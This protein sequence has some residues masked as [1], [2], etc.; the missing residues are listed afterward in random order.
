MMSAIQESSALNVAKGFSPRSIPPKAGKVVVLSS[1][2]LTDRMFLYTE[3][4]ETLEEFASTKVW[5][6]SANSPYGEALWSG[7]PVRIESF[8]EVRAFREFPHNYLR[9]LN[10]FVWDLRQ[11]PPSRL[12]MMRHVR[13]KHQKLSIRMLKLPAI[14]LSLMRAEEM[15]ETKLERLLLAY[16]RSQSATLR[17]RDDRP[18][19]L[20]TT[21]PFQFE[22]PAIVAAAR[23]LGIKTL[24]LIP[25]WD[26]VSTKNRMVF[27]YDGYMVWSEQGK[28]EL[29]QF[30]P[31]TRKLPVYVI[32]AP[33]FDTFFQPEFTQSRED[34]CASQELNPDLPI[35][36]YAVGSPNFLQEHYGAIQLA[37]KVVKG[38]LG[39]VQMLIRPHPIHDNGEMRRVF[40]RFRPR[41]VLQKTSEA[42][43]PLTARSQDREQIS[44]WVNTFKHADV[45]VNLSSTVTV[46][47][48]LFDRPVV[49]LDYDP[50]PGGP[51]QDLVKD[52]NH[53]WTHFKP[54]AESGGVWLVNNLDE[55]VDAV[56]SYLQ[57]PE[58]HRERRRWVTEHVCGFVD[59]QCGK[60]MAE[61][62]LDFIARPNKS[63]P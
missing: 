20:V 49:N 33:Q 9:R 37:E 47:A 54:I 6:T 26:N 59:G 4:L 50:E 14:L 22:Q 23:N 3:F 40:D 60:R 17:L 36:L 53:L 34:F 42:G 52:I 31:H 16:S 7:S 45:V 29:H 25:S 28:R 51:N 13:A 58:L 44:E 18:D 27:K 63:N 48:A 55:L 35:V 10:E 46:D 15:F 30:Y 32:G 11:Q 8:P 12:S 39:N 57:H 19:V 24:A 41:V 21:G 38:E 2:L 5:A 61:A 56:R 43:T 62:I 1:S